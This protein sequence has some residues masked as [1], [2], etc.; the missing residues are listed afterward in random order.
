VAK[1]V[2]QLDRVIIRFAGDSGDGM[3]LAGSDL[4]VL[5]DPKAEMMAL[6]S[7]KSLDSAD[8]GQD[9]AP[10]G[11]RRL[12]QKDVKRT[13]Q[14]HSVVQQV[15]QLRKIRGQDLRLDPPPRPQ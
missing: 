2:Q 1:H 12:S 6:H 4:F 5:A 13:E 7:R 9:L 8:V 15:G 14:R 11:L 10:S 3:Q